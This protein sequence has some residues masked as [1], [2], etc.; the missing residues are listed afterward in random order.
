[1]KSDLSDKTQTKKDVQKHIS[2]KET[3]YFPLQY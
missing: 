2:Q 1:M 3:I